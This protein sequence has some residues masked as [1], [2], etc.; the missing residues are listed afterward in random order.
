MRPRE[1]L[2]TLASN[3]QDLARPFFLAGFFRV[4]L[5]GL[6]ERGTTCGLWI[7]NISHC[8]VHETSYPSQ[9]VIQGYGKFHRA[10]SKTTKETN[11][12]SCLRGLLHHFTEKLVVTSWST[13]H[14]VE[15]FSFSFVYSKQ[16]KIHHFNIWTEC[17]GHWDFTSSYIS[18]FYLVV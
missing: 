4:S 6:S 9:R 5:D 18:C 15:C 2:V 13:Y 12:N 16:S 17:S 8:A 1:I 7:A 11:K 3:S 10:V 14:F